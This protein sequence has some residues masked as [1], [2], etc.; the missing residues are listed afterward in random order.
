MIARRSNVI[1]SCPHAECG[2]SGY[3]HLI[4]ASLYCLAQDLF[5][6]AGRI[7]VSRVKHGQSGIQANVDEPPG[8]GHIGFAEAFERTLSPERAGSEAEDRHLESGG[9][10]LP[11]FHCFA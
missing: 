6:Q 11:V 10:E 3:D 7:G 8:L 5:G 1:R 2:F 9:P 4:A